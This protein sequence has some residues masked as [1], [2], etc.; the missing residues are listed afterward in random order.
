VSCWKETTVGFQWVIILLSERAKTPLGGSQGRAAD[1]AKTG[2]Q[3]ER[4]SEPS[5]RVTL[6]RFPPR[7]VPSITGLAFR[8]WTRVGDRAGAGRGLDA[9]QPRDGTGK[10]TPLHPAPW[11]PSIASCESLATATHKIPGF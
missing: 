11:P 6:N 10:G 8:P 9:S 1:R 5:S 4:A 2:A 7:R 3:I